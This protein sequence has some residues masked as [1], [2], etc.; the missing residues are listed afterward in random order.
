[1]INPPRWAQKLLLDAMLWLES[2]GHEAPELGLLWKRRSGEG[3]SGVYM[4]D[5]ILVRYGPTR[6]RD[7][8]TGKR[9]PVNTDAK[10]VIL[11]ELA[12][13]VTPWDCHSLRFWGIAWGLYRWAKL[14]IRYCQW[15]EGSK[16]KGADTVYKRR[17]HD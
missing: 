4:G 9:Y 2:Q 12:H 1:M 14:P 17:Q 6:R 13:A 7:W 3:C 16:W 15:R 8:R 10:L 11:H 5:A